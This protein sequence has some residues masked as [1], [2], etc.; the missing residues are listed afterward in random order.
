[1]TPTSP[2]TGVRQSGAALVVGLVLLAALTVLSASAMRTATLQMVMSG[3]EMFREQAF[4]AAET[5]IEIAI[6]QG[7]FDTEATSALPRMLF[8]GGTVSADAGI[9]F[10]V[11][12]PVPGAA[13]SLGTETGGLQ[14]FHF[15]VTSVGM[16]PRNAASTHRQG[17]YI[18]GPQADTI[19]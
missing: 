6:A 12:T 3:N 13:F 4:Q 10:A 9:A 18:I 15:E 1:M 16:A 11:T 14:A 5:G 19:P 17:L 7:S 8:D 2:A